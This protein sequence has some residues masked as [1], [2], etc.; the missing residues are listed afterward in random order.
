LMPSPTA[1][2][3]SHPFV[4]A[5]ATNTW[6]NAAPLDLWS[7][8]PRPGRLQS[9]QRCPSIRRIGRRSQIPSPGSIVYCLIRWEFRD[10]SG[11][12]LPAQGVRYCRG[13]PLHDRD[14]SPDGYVG[15][16]RRR[17]QLIL[18]EYDVGRADAE[19]EPLDRSDGAGIVGQAYGGLSRA[20][21]RDG[22]DAP[23]AF[24]GPCV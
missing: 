12:V 7:R 17:A 18:R 21:D 6:Q 20:I 11:P 5:T 24:P 14:A 13:C 15:S 9:T 1:A 16:R 10:C 3:S 2:S 22:E 4:T 8:R 19:G 23:F